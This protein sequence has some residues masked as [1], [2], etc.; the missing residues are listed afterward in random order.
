[1]FAGFSIGAALGGLLAAAMIP[2]FG[3]RSVFLVGGLVPLLLLPF[4]FKALPESIRF[5][6]MMGGR[7][8]EVA[9]L[10]QR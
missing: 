10:L 4:L 8:R 6:A 2:A 9:N 7:D 1:M 5:L 3:W